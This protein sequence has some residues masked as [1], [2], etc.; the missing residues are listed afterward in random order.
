M[1]GGRRTLDPKLDIVFWMLFGADRNRDLL[2]SLLNAVLRPPEPIATVTVLHAQPEKA[3]ADEKSIALDVRVQLESGEQVD[4]EMQSQRRPA[5]RE[6]ALYYW[7]RLYAGQLLRGAEYSDLRRCAVILITNFAELVGSHFHSTFA[8]G[9]V[10]SGE[11]LTDHLELHVV[12]LPK[13][14]QAMERNEEPDL[15]AWGRF[16]SATGD[17]EL[18]EL[19]RSNPV[20]RSAKEALER[21]SADPEARLRAEQREMALLTYELDLAKVRR[22]G[23][24]E[25]KAEGHAEGR[26]EGH[27]EGKAE[28]RAQ[29]KAALLLTLL[30]QR[31]GPVPLQARATVEAASEVDLDRWTRGVLTASSL[32][33]LLA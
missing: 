3:N 11:R 27:A 18:E 4:V 1:G 5:Q 26:A 22:E 14:R 6:R 31:F 24:A 21:L 28:G 16:L 2:I 33:E 13:L 9:E 15:L 30:A 8:L 25:G 12:E 10:R 17:E 29:G 19:A 20:L 7:A 32:D 23:Y